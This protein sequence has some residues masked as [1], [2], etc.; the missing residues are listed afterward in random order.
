MSDANLAAVMVINQMKDQFADLAR[1][2]Y[3]NLTD[4]GRIDTWEGIEIGMKALPTGL[5][6]IGILKGLPRENLK[7][8]LDVLELGHW[9]L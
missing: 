7:A 1:T 9:T 3:D 4:D 2:I 5:T 8:I 6:L